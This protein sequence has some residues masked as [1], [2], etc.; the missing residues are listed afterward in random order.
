MP[1]TNRVMSRAAE[2]PR[3]A[4]ETHALVKKNANGGEDDEQSSRDGKGSV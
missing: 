4:S 1:A 3:E 2:V